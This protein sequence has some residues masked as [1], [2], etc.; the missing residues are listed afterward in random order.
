V[1][2]ACPLSVTFHRAFDEVPDQATALED[3]IA[4]GAS[5]VLTSGGKSSAELGTR[6]IAKLVEVSRGRIGILAGGG[7]TADNSAKILRATHV[8]E[9]HSGLSSVL[10]YPRVEHSQF[11]S[12]VRRLADSLATI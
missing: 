4:C 1:E 8:R 5:R 10:P 2:S 9:I 3:V 12:E 11:E 7:I 6:S